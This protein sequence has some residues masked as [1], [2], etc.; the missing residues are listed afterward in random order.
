MIVFVEFSVGLGGTSHPYLRRSADSL[1]CRRIAR[2]NA[3]LPLMPVDGERSRC[4]VGTL[5]ALA[6]LS[7]FSVWYS[8]TI[9]DWLVVLRWPFPALRPPGGVG[10]VG[11]SKIHHRGRDGYA[12]A[13]KSCSMVVCAEA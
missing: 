9:G 10:I 4:W 1:T 7:C 13:R 2:R 5:Q 11:P 3:A 6:N 12:W 8:G